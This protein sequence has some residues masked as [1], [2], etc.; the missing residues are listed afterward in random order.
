[1]LFIITMHTQY[2]ST[3]IQTNTQFNH[4]FNVLITQFIIK[5]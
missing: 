4:H 2:A 3:Q 1:M 5:I